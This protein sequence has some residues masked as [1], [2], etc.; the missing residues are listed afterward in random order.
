LISFDRLIAM[1]NLKPVRWDIDDDAAGARVEPG[2]YTHYSGVSLIQKGKLWNACTPTGMLKSLMKLLTA[3][4]L[5]FNR[6]VLLDSERELAIIFT[7]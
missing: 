1:P 4:A 3:I 2:C 6:A 7:H 5:F